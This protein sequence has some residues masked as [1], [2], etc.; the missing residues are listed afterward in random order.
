VA[1]PDPS[2]DAEA[3]RRE[4]EEARREAEYYRRIAEEAGRRRLRE[5]EALS[6]LLDRAEQAE[7]ALQQAHD[8][9]ERRVE[10]RT[11]ELT[12]ANADLSREVEERERAERALRAS[13]EAFRSFMSH[14]PGLAYIKEAD[15]TFVFA[16]EGFRHHLGLAPE[17][18]EGRTNAEIF[19]AQ[20]AAR[21][22]GDDRRILATGRAET[23]EEELDGRTWSTHKFVIPRPGG[24]PRLGGLSL[25]VTQARRTEAERRRLEQQVEQAQ[26]IDSLGVLAG[27]IAHDF[28][29]LLATILG[30]VALLRNDAVRGAT[31]E[32]CLADVEWAAQAAAGLCQQM[33][34]YAGRAACVAEPLD[35]GAL[36]REM[37][38]L[39]R[40]SVSRKLGL[41]LRLG[42]GL[43]VV[44]GDPSQLRQVVMN[45]VLNAAEAI[46]DADG[47]VTVTASAVHAD[48]ERLRCALL[49]EEVPE[50]RC[51]A[52][53]VADTGCG[54]DGA[55]QRRI[56]EPFYTTKFAGRGLGL[57]AV[58][59]IVRQ[60][61]GAIE[62]ESAPGRGTRMRVLFPAAEAAVPA[63]HSEP[64]PAPGDWTGEGLVLVVDDDPAIRRLLQR[65]LKQLGLGMLEA[66][67]GAEGIELFRRHAGRIRAAIVDLT[68]PHVDGVETLRE[69]RRLDP[70]VYV[71][72]ASGWAE[73]EV[74]ARFR[75]ERPDGFLRKP[76]RLE[77]VRDHLRAA[78]ERAGRGARA[79]APPPA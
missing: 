50:G 67:G 52:L 3:A 24:A 76:F 77:A 12:R 23:I 36:V 33:L 16:S 79:D 2:R 27:G 14:F 25:D 64:A 51:V 78:L 72:V 15:T 8:E 13:E 5:A 55:T 6:S 71:V 74:E 35:L 68:M 10:E 22:A 65:Q 1:E 60:L 28:N 20:F 4:A 40:S 66:S 69:V 44:V 57:A 11:A 26:R 49:G 53:E 18:V 39:L 32:A 30:N 59:G 45:L 73:A 7:R 46:G 29:N 38:Q 70:D 37:A 21:I 42:D 63:T 17:V 75:E 43:P 61:R 58:L 48:R 56:F 47:T 31:A 9:L 34:V 62:V 19:P 54:M 41:E